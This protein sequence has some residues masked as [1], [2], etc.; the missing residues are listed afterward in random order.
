MPILLAL[1]YPAVF[2]A[3]GLSLALA[4]AVFR[5][6]RS[7]AVGWRISSYNVVL[8]ASFVSI[9]FSA[10]VVQSQALRSFYRWGY[11]RA[12]F[13]PWEEPWKMPIWLIDVHAGKTLAYPLGGERGGSTATLFAVLVG[14]AV[15]WRETGG[16]RSD[17][18]SRRS[19]WGW[20]LPVWDSIPT[21]VRPG[22]LNTWFRRSASWL[23]WGRRSSWPDWPR[24]CAD[25]RWWARIGVL[26]AVGIGLIARD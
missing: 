22:S 3:A 14:V 17:F 24:P 7:D 2:V 11:W 12:S 16:Y 9:Y 21:A 13:P 8:I 19:R 18:S 1:S 26:A 15:L 4:P 10:T 25:G 6:R 23:A 20:P 5:H